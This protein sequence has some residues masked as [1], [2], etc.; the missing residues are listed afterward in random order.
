MRTCPK[1]LALLAVT[2]A[3]MLASSAQA[4]VFDPGPT[5]GSLRRASGD[6]GAA[7]T[8]RFFLLPALGRWVPASFWAAAPRPRVQAGGAYSR[9]LAAFTRR[10]TSR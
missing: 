9:P 5:P 4:Q 10:G 8:A 6:D 7:Q 1:R 3:V 2:L